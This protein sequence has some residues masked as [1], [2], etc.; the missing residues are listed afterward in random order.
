MSPTDKKY[1][2]KFYKKD[3]I[4]KNVFSSFFVKKTGKCERFLTS[5]HTYTDIPLK[6]IDLLQKMMTLNHHNRA[7]LQELIHHQSFKK[8]CCEED[9]LAIMQ[10]VP[11]ILTNHIDAPALN[12]SINIDKFKYFRGVIVQW[13]FDFYDMSNKMPLFVHAVNIFDK[14]ISLKDVALKDYVKV[15]TTCVYVAQYIFKRQVLASVSVL[16]ASS[17]LVK[18]LL[19]NNDIKEQNVTWE[20][21]VDISDDILACFDFDLYRVTFDVL[22]L[23]R[24]IPVDMT[25]VANVLINNTG[26]Y[27]NNMLINKYITMKY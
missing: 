16:I 18:T 24:G 7:T 6:V 26:A 12:R 2:K 27:D 3:D 13:M 8:F 17:Q 14:Y 10:G 23:K 9:A 1:Y 21:I 15:A 22:L 19:H 4:I 20:D 25:V 5:F 11:E